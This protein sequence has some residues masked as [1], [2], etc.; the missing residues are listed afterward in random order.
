MK[1]PLSYIHLA[2]ISDTKLK[3]DKSKQLQVNKNLET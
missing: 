3:T 2:L 1:A